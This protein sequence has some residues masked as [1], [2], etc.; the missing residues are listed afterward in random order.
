M[1]FIIPIKFILGWG[2]L[3]APFQD[4]RYSLFGGLQLLYLE[5]YSKR[6]NYYF[7]VLIGCFGQGHEPVSDVT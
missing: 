7:D 2:M 3:G 4:I 1:G 5:F 6:C